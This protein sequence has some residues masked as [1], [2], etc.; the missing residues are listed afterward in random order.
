MIVSFTDYEV[1]PRYDGTSWKQARIGESS[2]ETGPWTTIDTINLLPDPNPADPA[3]KS[4]T[5]DNATMTEGWYLVTFLDDAGNQLV[6]DPVFN[7]IASSYEIMAS[8]DDINAYLDGTVVEADAQNTKLIQVS[9]ARVIKAQLS[10]VVD[11]TT[12]ATWTTPEATP[13]TIREVAGR[14]IAAQLYY[15]ETAK[16]SVV[17][18]P[19]HYSQILY[20]QAMELL[21]E[22]AAGSVIIPDVPVTPLEAMSSLDFFPVDDTN[23]AFSMGMNL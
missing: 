13:D 14:L 5:T 8:L 7:G 1:T 2:Q 17:M 10:Q 11:A 22:I 23:R 4:F 16:S 3:P 12:M 20:N 21:N 18:P 9:V 15:N 19:D 6:T